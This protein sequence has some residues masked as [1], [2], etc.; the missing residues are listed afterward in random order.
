MSPPNF[1][2]LSSAS[3][4]P[5]LLRPFQRLTE[6]PDGRFAGLLFLLPPPHSPTPRSSATLQSVAL[7]V[8]D[9]LRLPDQH[10]PLR[11]FEGHQLLRWQDGRRQATVQ[12]Q[13]P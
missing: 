1:W 11:L 4:F 9:P 10:G 8:E 5:L 6:R 2:F 12:K 7:L 13:T 3:K